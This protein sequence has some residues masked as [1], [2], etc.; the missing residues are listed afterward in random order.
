[1]AT[2][3]SADTRVI[4]GSR[5]DCES[6]LGNVLDD[7]VIGLFAG[8]REALGVLRCLPDVPEPGPG[9]VQCRGAAQVGGSSAIAS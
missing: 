2:S 5:C 6:C 4:N 7:G 3:A 8:G 1:M 9:A